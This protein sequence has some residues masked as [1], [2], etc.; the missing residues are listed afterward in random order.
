M[1]PPRRSAPLS[2]EPLTGPRI[3]RLLVLAAG[4]AATATARGETGPAT[5]RAPTR[6]S[7]GS[8]VSPWFLGGFSGLAAVEPSALPDW[9][10]SAELW[11]MELPRFAVELPAGNRDQGFTHDVRLAGALYVDRALGGSG[12]HAGGIV[13]VMRARIRRAGEQGDLTIGE[14]LARI[15]YR[16]L[17]LGPRGPFVNPWLGAGPQWPLTER[18][19]LAGRRYA[20]F[21]VQVLATVHAGWRF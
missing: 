13:N 9:R 20:L 10:F 19:T 17:P 6:I 15:G 11:S 12:L 2:R 18:P 5:P 21:P 16:W 4:L 14:L 7:L 1:T 3:P 8:D